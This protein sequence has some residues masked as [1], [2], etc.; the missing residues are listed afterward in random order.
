MTKFE[1]PAVEVVQGRLRLYLTYVTP[2]DLFLT[3]NFYSVERLY[4]EQS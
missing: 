2:Q 4:P 1:R 3:D